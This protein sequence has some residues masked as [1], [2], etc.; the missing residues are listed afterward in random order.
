MT[1]ARWQAIRQL[2][3]SVAD[4]VA[5]AAATALLEELET[6]PKP[7]LVS[8]VDAG[9]H[10]DMDA[11]TF[12]TSVA[13]ITP[14][15]ARLT[16]AGAAGSGMDGLRKIGVEAERAMLEETGGANTHRGA[17][18]GLGL[19]C[20]AAGTTWSDAATQPFW[21]AEMLG[22][23]VRRRWG[24]AIMRG[25]IPLRSHGT[26][27]L[28]R[29]GAGGARAQAATGFP[30][31]LDVGLPALRLGRAIVPGDPEAARVQSFFALL[32]SM[33][34]TNLLHRGGADG[35]RFAQEQAAAF[36]GQGGIK[37]AEWRE[38]AAVV[39][40]AF[41][42]RGLSPGGCADLLAITLFLDALASRS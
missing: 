24:A 27:A 28:R 7:G 4:D 9:S 1:A 37:G 26:D 25:P 6:W 8:H 29:F 16:L 15:F 14:F 36:L 32:E 41:I 11:G 40:R 5:V 19:L 23:T 2:P 38:R 18:L 12:R 34:D 17:I 39:H 21:G 31:A 35:L 33:E 42:A 13:A 20:A 10:T 3:D 30:H 22:A